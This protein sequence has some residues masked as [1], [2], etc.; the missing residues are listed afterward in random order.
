MFIEVVFN[1]YM[2]FKVIIKVIG[3]KSSVFIY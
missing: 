3:I 2:D 1:E